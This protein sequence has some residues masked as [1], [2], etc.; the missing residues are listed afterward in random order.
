MFLTQQMKII[1]FKQYMACVNRKTH[2]DK[3][4]TEND[5]IRHLIEK[6]KYYNDE[7]KVPYDGTAI[8]SKT[9]EVVSAITREFEK[10]KLP[11]STSKEKNHVLLATL[12]NVHKMQGFVWSKVFLFG[13]HEDGKFSVE[14]GDD[15]NEED[16]NEE[17]IN[18]NLKIQNCLYTAIT[19]AEEGNDLHF[20][21]FEESQP[22]QEEKI[23]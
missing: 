10:E 17:D 7:L 14:R 1:K 2:F 8:I 12:N 9:F 22:K 16:I 13:I 11:I 20:V 19:R 4:K 15:I 18:E 6:V 21:S 3:A 23:E 5:A